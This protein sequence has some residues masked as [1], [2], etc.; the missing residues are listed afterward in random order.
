MIPAIADPPPCGR[1]RTA[2]RLPRT[3][4]RA[5]PAGRASALA[6]SLVFALCAG[7]EAQE[8]PDTV[9]SVPDSLAGAQA[10]PDSLQELPPDS[11]EA[12][13]V[14]YNLPSERVGP[15]A[16]WS[17]G[18]FEWDR[19]AIMASRAVTLLELFRETPGMVGLLGGDYGTPV[20]MSFAGQGGAGYR[21]FRDGFEIS[22]VAGAVADLQLVPLVGIGRVRLDRS[23][24]QTIV[25]MWSFAYEDG[26][27]FSVIEAGT[28]DL[29]TNLFR[30]VFTDPTVLFGS[31]GAGLERTDTRGR[32]ADRSEGGNRT[33]GWVRYQ[34]HVE[35]RFAAGL[36]Y[37]KST[38]QTRVDRYIPTVQRS[39][40][41][42]RAGVRVADGVTVEAYGAR[43]GFGVDGDSAATGFGG[44]RR[45]AGATLAARRDG[46]WLRASYRLFDDELPSRRL[47]AAAGFSMARWGGASAAVAT[48]SWAG[49]ATTSWGARVWATPVR[50]ATLFG[51]YETGTY[52]ARD[53][54]VSELAIPPA[55]APAGDGPGEPLF[56]ERETLRVGLELSRWGVTVGGAA[57]YAWSDV[58]LPLATQ[59]DLGAPVVSGVHRNGYEGRAVLP[60]PFEGLTLEGSWVWWDE[61]GPYLPRHTYQGAFEFNRV[62]KETGNLEFWVSLGV[63]GHDPMLSFVADGADELVVGP[64]GGGLARVPFY[65][66]WYGRLQIRVL[67]VR[68]WLGIDNFTLRRDLRSYPERPLPITRTTYAI[69]WDLWN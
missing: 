23:L 12:D 28:G 64:G 14:Y 33:G 2:R 19:H 30:G 20:S 21:L 50:F 45:Q 6:A 29:D 39:D 4:A 31:I 18:V 10:L 41:V 24:G 9:P 66:S 36:E 69:R 61:E 13:T 63:R 38:A 27:P 62:Y 42:A 35:D 34:F 59:L 67:T 22:P 60:M 7:A 32:D 54:P 37:R 56:T 44:T 49:T 55:P 65:Q 51:A 53:R 11:L 3:P 15:P 5:G 52:G 16:G 26:R 47:D 58:V 57:L 8:P 43:T 25:E 17:T 46:G 68:L 1:L 40:V 48:S